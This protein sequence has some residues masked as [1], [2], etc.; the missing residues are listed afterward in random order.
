M[1]AAPE[2]A[3]STAL[4]LRLTG[5]RLGQVAAPAGAGLLAGVAGTAAPFVLLGGLLLASAAMAARTGPERGGGTA[6][7]A[8]GAPAATAEE[9]GPTADEAGPGAEG[10]GPGR[11]ATA[12][13]ARKSARRDRKQTRREP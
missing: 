1:Q 7:G 10:T 13:A 9:A 8:G 3:R 11:V 5:N 12:S 6:P 2:R 4:A